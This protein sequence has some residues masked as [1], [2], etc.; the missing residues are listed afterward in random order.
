MIHLYHGTLG[1]KRYRFE[2]FCHFGTRKAALERIGRRLRDG[3]EGIPLILKLCFCFEKNEILTIKED[4]GSNQPIALARAMKDY[5]KP[6]DDKAYETF[7][8]IRS[9]LFQ[10]KSNHEEFKKI[11]FKMLRQAFDNMGIKAIQYPNSVEHKGSYSFAVVSPTR[12]IC[13]GTEILTPTK[14]DQ[15]IGRFK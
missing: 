4:W 7:E 8:G 1:K 9:D 15:E 10:R 13:V 12:R 2:A 14:I 3:D 11:G 6:I 5:F